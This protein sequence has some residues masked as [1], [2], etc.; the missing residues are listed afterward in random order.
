MP[1]VYECYRPDSRYCDRVEQHTIKIVSSVWSD[2]DQSRATPFLRTN[3]DTRQSLLYHQ[4]NYEIV[5]NSARNC[6][7]SKINAAIL[8]IR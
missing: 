8:T 5:K 6:Y 7:G 3:L 2:Q 4:I 1:L